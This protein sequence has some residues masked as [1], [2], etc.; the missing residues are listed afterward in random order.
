METKF[1]EVRDRGTL[2]P[3]MCQ[4]IKPFLLKREEFWLFTN[5]GF[6][7]LDLLLLV[8]VLEP[9]QSQYDKHNWG[10][11]RTMYHAHDYIEKNFGELESGAVIDVEYILG[12]TTEP[13]KSESSICAWSWPTIYGEGDYK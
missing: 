11:T 1:F 4:L 7:P 9:F 2:M 8:T 10:D 5:S 6:S 13:K 3:V 12:E